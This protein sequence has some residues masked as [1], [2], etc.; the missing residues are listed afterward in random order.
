M[1]KTPEVLEPYFFL[2]L[3]FELVGT[4]FRL[5]REEVKSNTNG[6][7]APAERMELSYTHSIQKD[8]QLPRTLHRESATLGLTWCIFS[9]IDNYGPSSPGSWPDD[10]A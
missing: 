5:N 8:L 9:V 10:V 4:V 2:P 3:T 7:E 6:R 1:A